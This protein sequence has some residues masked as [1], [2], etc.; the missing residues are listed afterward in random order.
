MA[1]AAERVWAI[2]DIVDL[3]RDPIAHL[4][5][6]RARRL[7]ERCPRELA[8]RGAC[9][10]PGFMREEAVQAVVGEAAALGHLAHRSS[11]DA[12]PFTASPLSRERHRG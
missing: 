11:P 9:Q 10:L 6:S 8:A 3:D 5:G 2:G 12:T 4:A 7:V 1:T